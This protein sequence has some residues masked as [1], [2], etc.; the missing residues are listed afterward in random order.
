VK[1]HN[2]DWVKLCGEIQGDLEEEAVV[3]EVYATSTVAS[4][5]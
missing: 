4:A 5:Y 2:R 1:N 3:D